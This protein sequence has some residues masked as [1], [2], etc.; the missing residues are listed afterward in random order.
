MIRALL[1]RRRLLDEAAG[2]REPE[3]P[4]EKR[5]E[6]RKEFDPNPDLFRAGLEDLFPPPAR[7]RV[8]IAP[9]TPH[10]ADP[11]FREQLSPEG[12]AFYDRNPGLFIMLTE[13][14]FAEPDSLRE[15]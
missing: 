15:P 3:A 2:L 14:L 12:K 8:N 5:G 10:P 7:K 4:P 1:K 11:K 6:N 13:D 9:G